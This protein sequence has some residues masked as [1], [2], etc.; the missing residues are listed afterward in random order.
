MKKKF[1]SSEV[2]RFEPSPKAGLSNDEVQVRIREGLVNKTKHAV[3]K[4]YTEIIFTNVFSFFNI[5]LFVIAALMIYTGQYRSLFFLFVLIP[6]IIIGLYQDLK[7]RRLMSKLRLLTQ[8]KV[9]V[10]REGDVINVDKR[11]VVLD[12]I[13]VLNADSQIVADGIVMEGNVLVNESLLTGEALSIEKHPGDTVLSGTF[14]VSGHALV[15]ADKIGK[16]SYVETIQGAANKFKRSPSQILVALRRLFKTLGF[17][18]IVS[19]AAT[20]TVYALQGKLTS[21]EGFKECVGPLSGFLVAM[22]PSGLYLLTSVALTTAVIN[23]SKKNAQVQDFYSIEMLART[24]VLCVDKTGTITDG[25]MSVKKILP[26][27]SGMPIVDIEQIIANVINATQDQNM[28]ALAMK[29]YFKYESTKIADAVIPFNSDIKYSAASFRNIG[30]YVIGAIEYIPILNKE[31]VMKRAE[32]FT[33]YGYRVLLL[34]QSKSPI[35]KGKL[36]G[37]LSPIA[38]IIMQDN[39]RPD[40]LKTFKWFKDNQVEIKVIS[41]DDAITV[42]EIARQAGVSGSD[43]YISLAHLSDEEV[44]D[45][46]LKY[47]VFGRVTP[48]QKEIIVK[49]LKANKKTVAMTGDGINDILALK[50]ADCS[51]AL[52]SGSDAARNVSHIVLMDSNFDTLPSVVAEGRRVINNLQRTSTLFL[53]KTFFA[54]FFT[55]YFL[56]A[57]IICKDSSI[58]YPFSTNNMYLWEIFIIGVVAFFL[59]LEPNSEPLRGHFLKNVFKKAFPGAIVIISTVLIIL[60]LFYLQKNGVCYVG[61]SPDYAEDG[62]TYLNTSETAKAMSVL[63]FTLSSLIVLYR[64]ITPFT[65]DRRIVFYSAVGFTA[66]VLLGLGFYTHSVGFNMIGTTPLEDLAKINILDINFLSM[67]LINYFEVGIIVIVCGAIYMTATVIASILR[68]YKKNA[69]N[70]SNN[71][72]SSK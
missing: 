65:K 22:I 17:I 20:I 34:A 62:M 24:E 25:S 30:T 61:I 6:N 55:L 64:V 69:E 39:V 68:R 1:T 40:V 31:G 2:E 53:T 3:G 72:T 51:I 45:A 50:R 42:S 57:S 67:N 56:V 58:M 10:M 26:L 60:V 70:Q 28:T 29:K 27:V 12:D 9:L 38:F 13:M 32:E 21:V 4:S 54:I 59:A 33:Y 5:L 41:G 66:V 52:A 19:A 36:E 44:A 35:N 43:R 16:E 23:L 7:A 14:V 8:P 11:D 46:A 47:N 49:T 48:E 37:Q 71:Q 18:V 63:A 15:K